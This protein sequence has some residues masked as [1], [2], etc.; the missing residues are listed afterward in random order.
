[1]IFDDYRSGTVY[2][3]SIIN[4]TLNHPLL[5]NKSRIKDDRNNCYGLEI[6]DLNER[7]GVLKCFFTTDGSP[8]DKTPRSSILLTSGVLSHIDCT[9]RPYAVE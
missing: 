1:M 3:L 2:F 9:P 7:H 6:G 5:L 8:G 4:I